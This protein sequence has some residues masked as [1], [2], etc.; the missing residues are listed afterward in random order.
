[1][2]GIKGFVAQGMDG[3]KRYPAQQQP[4]NFPTGAW[5][6]TPPKAGF[7]KFII[8]SP[9]G[10]SDTGTAGASGAYSEITKR[11]STAQTVTGVTGRFNASD[12]S[13]TFPDGVV[14]T[15]TR[16]VNGTPGAASGGDVNLAGSAGGAAGLGT[17]GGAAGSSTGGAGAPANAP[18][19]GGAGGPGGGTS[20]DGD[21]LSPGGGGGRTGSGSA[22]G[23]EAMILAVFIKE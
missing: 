23:G 19:K 20:R 18:Y 1:M 14:V 7:W 6:F 21:G 2:R 10:G 12:S 4:Y 13:V 5:S 16:A 15:C 22:D 8:W 9:G 11:L 17:G 3:R